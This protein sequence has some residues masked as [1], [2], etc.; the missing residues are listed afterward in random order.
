MIVVRVLCFILLLR[1]V[2]SLGPIQCVGNLFIG[3]C[4]FVHVL[5]TAG[6]RWWPAP[7]PLLPLLMLVAADTWLRVGSFVKVPV[8]VVL[9]CA[10]FDVLAFVGLVSV[11]VFSLVRAAVGIGLTVAYGA[12]ARV[13][14]C[15][16]SVNVFS[17]FP[18]L[19]VNI[20]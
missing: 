19:C 5:G 18:F 1:V 2:A 16:S 9:S 14:Q 7:V 15:Q 11:N 4:T 6:R 3:S 13:R 20:K 17:I 8:K 12:R 10:V